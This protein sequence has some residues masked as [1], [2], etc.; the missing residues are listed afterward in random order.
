MNVLDD[1]VRKNI[2]SWLNI[3]TR[4]VLDVAL[5][6]PYMLGTKLPSR[7]YTE[8]HAGTCAAVRVKVTPL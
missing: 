7:I 1:I 2:K 5:Y 4:G 6:H 3:Q 8:A